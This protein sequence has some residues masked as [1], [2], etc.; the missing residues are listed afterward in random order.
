MQ[1]EL[2]E[3]EK[4]YKKTLDSSMQKHREKMQQEMKNL[5]SHNTKEYWK[6]LN[7]GKKTK[8]PDI[9]IDIFFDFYKDLNAPQSDIDPHN[10]PEID[11]D[12]I[13]HVNE[14]INSHITRE[15]I[16]KAIKNLKV[17]KSCGEDHIINE[18]IKS[19][20]QL[21]ISIYEKLFNII[22][23]HDVIPDIWLVGYIKPLYKNKGNKFDPKNYRPITI[24]SCLGKLFTAILNERLNKYSEE[25]FVVKENQC[26]F[27][28]GYSTTDN[29]FTLFSFFEILKRKKKKLYCAFIDFEKAFDKVWREDL[30]YKLL[31]HNINGIMY[32]VILNMYENVKSCVTSNNCTSDFF[33]CC[34]GVKQG[35]NLQPFLF[36]TFLND[37]ESFFENRDIVGLETVTADIE[38]QLNV[39]LKIFCI[40]YADDTVL[41]AESPDEL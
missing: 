19:T 38:R 18:Y 22:F 29:L 16:I 3:A 1:Q 21:F 33:P 24:L 5:R 39:F 13:N 14:E 12:V 30:W 10:L 11:P 37:L 36:S 6:I 9:P 17:N 34:N 32:K 28:K 15:E 23:D 27:R 4:Q 35:E 31:L 26:G 7:R 20:Y 25:F 2:F 40:L 41:M 8:Q